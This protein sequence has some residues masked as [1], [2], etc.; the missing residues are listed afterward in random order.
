MTGAR[1]AAEEVLEVATPGDFH[2]NMPHRVLAILAWR[3]GDY[4][5]AAEHATRATSLIRDQGDRY[6]QA[7][8]VRQLAA[9]I[10]SVEP[11]LAAELLGVADGLVPEVRVIARDEIADS[12]L[13][14]HLVDTLGAA[15]MASVVD[16]ARR[17][18]T[19]VANATI[20]RALRVIR[21]G[22][23]ISADSQR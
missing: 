9:L 21:A 6:V 10:G 15:E 14:A 7:A 4:E 5:A 22:G 18:D 2:L 16:R 8:S 17:Y 1:R 19:R 13:R 12:R 11:L 23:A 20:D 3:E